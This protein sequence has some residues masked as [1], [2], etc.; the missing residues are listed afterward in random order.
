MYCKQNR[1]QLY[2]PPFSLTSEFKLNF[3]FTK[4]DVADDS[5]KKS[6]V[7]FYAYSTK[8]TISGIIVPTFRGCVQIVLDDLHERGGDKAHIVY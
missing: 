8:E 7:K 3:S 4:Q 1:L 2:V 5:G 6:N